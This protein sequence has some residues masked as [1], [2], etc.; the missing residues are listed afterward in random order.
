MDTG[1]LREERA[2]T[3]KVWADYLTRR[4][5]ANLV[6]LPE[7]M[8]GLTGSVDVHFDDGMIISF[9]FDAGVDESTPSGHTSETSAADSPRGSKRYEA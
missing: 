4:I 6:R 8:T 9:D 2:A 1:E 7:N 5:S 3:V